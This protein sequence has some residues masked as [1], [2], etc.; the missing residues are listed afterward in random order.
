VASGQPVEF[1]FT[2]H[3]DRIT[4]ITL[5]PDGNKIVSTSMDN[6]ARVWN[7]QNGL[8][9]ASYYQ[10]GNIKELSFLAFL[11]DGSRLAASS[12]DGTVYLWN[13]QSHKPIASYHNDH[14][15]KLSSIV[16]SPDGTQ[17]MNFSVDGTTQ[18]WNATNGQTIQTP[19]PS[20]RIFLSDSRKPII[21]NIN[22]EWGREEADEALLLFPVDN[23]NCGYCA[24]INGKFVRTGKTKLTTIVDMSKV[25]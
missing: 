17:L 12:L 11:P 2:G 25:Q 20:D 8:S 3:T 13:T 24:Y 15:N 10:D 14:T 5:S 6:T 23:P 19:Q 22:R 4:F 7:A 9:S 16:F 21:F 18:I 1:S